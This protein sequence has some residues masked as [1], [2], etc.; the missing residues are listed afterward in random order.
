ML[1]EKSLSIIMFTINRW[2]KCRKN[3]HNT[4]HIIMWNGKIEFFC[5]IVQSI[6]SDQE[7]NLEILLLYYIRFYNTKKEW[8]ATER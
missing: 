8:V 7:D 6:S 3:V 4:E 2:G 5:S 1:Y